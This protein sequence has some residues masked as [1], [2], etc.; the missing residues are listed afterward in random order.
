[1]RIFLVFIFLISTQL[2][3]TQIS[4]S[5]S[6]ALQKGD[7][8]LLA[9]FFSETVEI[10]IE[11]EEGFYSQKQAEIIVS[12]FFKKNKPT[13]YT[14]KHEGGSKSK[15]QFTIGTLVTEKDTFRTHLLYNKLNNK[16][17]IIELRIESA[18]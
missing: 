3:F 9:H 17:Q 18:N 13:S 10:S 11:N 4:D 2:A 14:V 12:S 1:M 7:S 5:L 15:S 16:I 6:I 8:K